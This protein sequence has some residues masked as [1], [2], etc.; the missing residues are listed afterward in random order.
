M[1]Q[2]S[3]TAMEALTPTGVKVV[4]QLAAGATVTKAAKAAQI[5]RTT[6]YRWMR[7][8]DFLAALNALRA[9][10]REAAWVHLEAL[11]ALA[12]DVIVDH[13]KKK[14]DP[15]V[16]LEILK[17]AGYLPGRLSYVGSDDAQRLIE[18]QMFR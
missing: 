9:D 8:P 1:M 16:A 7:N 3:A 18:E 5:D 17:G 10:M 12:L 2:R 11:V 14:K 6:V 13:L 15:R 4:E